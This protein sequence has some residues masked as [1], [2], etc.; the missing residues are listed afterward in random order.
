MLINQS[1]MMQIAKDLSIKL[2]MNNILKKICKMVQFYNN[3]LPHRY[4]IPAVWT[5]EKL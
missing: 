1:I 3:V 4:D 5:E 2:S